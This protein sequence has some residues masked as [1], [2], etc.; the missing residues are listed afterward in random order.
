[1]LCRFEPAEAYAY[2]HD[3]MMTSYD[4]T[5]TDNDTTYTYDVGLRRIKKDVNETV[6]KFIYDGWNSVA[7]YDGRGGGGIGIGGVLIDGRRS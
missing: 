3:N 4:G 1:M 7:E 2:N 5:G 6:T